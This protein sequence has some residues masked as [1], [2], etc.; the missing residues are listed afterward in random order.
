MMNRSDSNRLFFID[1][2]KAMA[3]ILVVLGHSI[4]YYEEIDEINNI[5]YVLKTVIYSVHVRLFFVIAGYLCHSQVKKIYFQKKIQRI[6]IPF[7]MFSILKI[8]Y[9]NGVIFEYAYIKYYIKSIL[10]VLLY[11]QTYWFSYCL[12]AIF[13][14]AP[15]FWDMNSKKIA[16]CCVSLIIVNLIINI[17][18]IELTDLFQIS[19][20][21]YY[22]TFFLMGMFLN[23]ENLLKEG[24]ILFENKK[25]ILVIDIII[26]IIL[27]GM[28]MKG[29]NSVILS[30][31]LAGCLMVILYYIAIK[32]KNKRIM[33]VVSIISNY[34]YQ[35][36]LL[37]SLFKVILFKLL[38]VT[39]NVSQV[40][41]FIITVINIFLSCICCEVA[42]KIPLINVALGL[43]Y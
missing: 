27:T 43:K 24:G 34:S 28:K 23:K 41:I 42:K 16:F 2:L 35:I 39:F 29:I 9:I 22:I 5:F 12:F 18:Q 36:M 1:C 3:I 33:K 11:G 15:I 4:S 37:D 6:L 13:L 30:Y 26:T 21:I 32:I 25:N 14:V 10:E 8:I 40:W 31:L 19:S 7:Y 38:S 20:A 17:Y